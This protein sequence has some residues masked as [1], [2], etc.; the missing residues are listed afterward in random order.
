MTYYSLLKQC[1]AQ[2]ELVSGAQAE[3][4]AETILLFSFALSRVAFFSMLNEEVQN[5]RALEKMC[6]FIEK[7][8]T[9]CPLAYVLGTI[10]FRNTQYQ[11][12]PGVLIPR[13]E[14]EILVQEAIRTIQVDYPKKRVTVLELGFGAGVIGIELQKEVPNLQYFG[15][16]S[17]TEAYALA[18]KNAATLGLTQLQFFHEDFFLHDKREYSF[19]S[20]VLLVISNPPYIPSSKLKDLDEQVSRFEPHLALDGGLDGGAFYRKLIP[21]MASFVSAFIFEIGANQRKL[22]ESITCAIPNLKLCFY[23]DYQG[24]DRVV[25]ISVTAPTIPS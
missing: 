7:R 23:K 20:D 1:A 17:A 16:D 3:F 8:K 10:Q 25:K 14:T 19:Q 18:K 21:S 12:A 4:E 6:H 11:V 22:I 24:I 5:E 15:W 13:P 9:G 2:L